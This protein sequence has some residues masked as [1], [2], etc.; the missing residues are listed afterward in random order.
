MCGAATLA[1]VYSAFRISRSQMDIWQ[2]NK[3]PNGDGGEFTLTCGLCSDALQQGLHSIIIRA[4]NPLFV[5]DLCKKDGSI[6]AVL[7][8][9][10]N[11]D[12]ILGHFSVV[13]NITKTHVILY[14]PLSGP[15]T[16]IVKSDLVELL[17]PNGDGCKISGNI[18]MAVSDIVS[19]K[20]KCSSCG[21]TIPSSMK[22]Q[23]CGKEILLQP[24]VVL[25]CIDAACPERT[26]QHI[27]CPYCNKDQDTLIR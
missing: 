12:T 24:I 15:P 1:M 23:K 6:G 21:T 17:R 22:C 14:D 8:Y 26:W 27:I 13:T 11:K 25:G 2:K 7:N 9:R 4:K 3:V 5:L 19:S 10:L 16:R 18:I 20:I